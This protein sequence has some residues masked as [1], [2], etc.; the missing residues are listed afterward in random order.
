MKFIFTAAQDYM[1]HSPS[2]QCS[3]TDQQH[4]HTLV[5]AVAAACEV[6]LKSNISGSYISSSQ[7]SSTPQHQPV[8]QG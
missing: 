1:Q 6:L 4:P 8:L 7:Y 5:L 2:V 3:E